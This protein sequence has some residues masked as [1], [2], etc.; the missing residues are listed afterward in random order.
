MITGEDGNFAFNRLSAGK[1][2]LRG[3][4]GGFIRTVYEQHEQFSTA[5]VTGAGLNTENLILRLVPAAT[6]T[7]KVLDERGDPVRNA[8]VGLYSEDRDIGFIQVTP[9][10]FTS[11]DDLGSYEFAPVIPG[12]YFVAV[13][14]T[15]WYAVPP[16]LF[17]MEGTGNSTMSSLD[18]LRAH[19]RF[20]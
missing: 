14:A 19:T 8:R 4:R 1:Y 18:C 6:I 2:S 3:A 17:H 20:A 11:T 15:P 5:I 13:T 12:I 10:E 7:G 16:A 9:F